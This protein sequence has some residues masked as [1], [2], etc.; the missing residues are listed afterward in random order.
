MCMPFINGCSS[1]L[2][3]VKKLW[4]SHGSFNAITCLVCTPVWKG[5]LRRKSNLFVYFYEF[6]PSRHK[7]IVTWSNANFRYL[8]FFCLWNILKKLGSGD[9]E[10]QLTIMYMYIYSRWQETIYVTSGD[11]R[12]ENLKLQEQSHGRCSGNL[13]IQ[14]YIAPII[15]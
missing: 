9:V 3:M 2:E 5:N 8:K 4:F 7:E 1:K 15:Q 6:F 13:R 11:T 10:W 14:R 12:R